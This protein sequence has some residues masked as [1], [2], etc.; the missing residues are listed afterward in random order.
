MGK[1]DWAAW[2]RAVPMFFSEAS[3][4]VTAKPSRAMGSDS[5]PPPQPMSSSESPSKGRKDRPSRPK[6][7]A[8]SVRIK[9]RRTGLNLC[10]GE[11]FPAGSHHSAAMAENLA[12]SLGS[13]EGS[14][15]GAV[16]GSREAESAMPF[17]GLSARVERQS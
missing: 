6:W 7:A 4:P 5:S 15:E 2:A 1:P 8:T 17:R 14:G 11:N 16:D 10:R 13:N 12:T 3:A 9:D